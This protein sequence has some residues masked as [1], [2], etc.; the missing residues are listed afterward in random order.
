MR[1]LSLGPTSS[2]LKVPGYPGLYNGLVKQTEGLSEREGW[3]ERQREEGRERK[4]KGGE[5]KQGGEDLPTLRLC[6]FFH[7]RAEKQASLS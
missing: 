1:S 6:V 4:G 3:V 7:S 2:T 5:G